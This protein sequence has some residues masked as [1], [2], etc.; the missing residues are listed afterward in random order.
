MPFMQALKVMLYERVIRSKCLP[1]TVMA[2]LDDVLMKLSSRH[3]LNGDPGL[4]LLTP[5]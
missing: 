2:T 1:G 3:G 4:V 5:G